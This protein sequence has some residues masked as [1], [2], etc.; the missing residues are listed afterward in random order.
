MISQDE[1]GS[2]AISE[3]SAGNAVGLHLLFAAGKRPDRAAIR[4]FVLSQRS[5]AISHDPSERATGPD[6]SPAGDQSRPPENTQQHWIELL[7]D[8]LTFDLIGLAPGLHG[9]LPRIDYR[10]GFDEAEM[11]GRLE[12]VSLVPGIHLAAGANTLPVMR[13]LC[14]IACD[15]VRHFAGIEAVAWPPAGT[16]IGR[17]YFESV[18]S[19]WL[20]GGAFPAL[21]LTA[22]RQMPEGALQ[23]VGLSFWVGQELQIEP[24]LSADTV[25]AARLGVRLVNHLV[26]VGGIDRSERVVGPDGSRLVMRPS[27]NGE[28]IRVTHE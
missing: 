3:G 27:R 12:P 22:F 19:A 25:A 4:D 26:M 28:L 11:T 7:R 6:I 14:S 23:S 21:G 5:L 13:G 8:G 10:F 20:E 15:L 17:R 9:S 1:G 16:G 2:W 18:T 24:P